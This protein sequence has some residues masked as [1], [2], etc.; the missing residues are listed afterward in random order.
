MDGTVP[1]YDG[2][3]RSA[4]PYTLS[5]L[6]AADV[7]N[8]QTVLGLYDGERLTEDWRLATERTRTGDELGVL[9]GG[10]LDLDAVDGICLSST[11]PTLIREWE[12]LAAR[13][14][15]APILVVGPGVKT[16]IPIRYDDPREVG[17]DRIVNSVAAKERYGA[18][19]IVVDFGTST[20]FDVVS[21][22]GEYVGGV[23]APGIETSMEALFARAAR[24]V[25][26]DYVE[27]PSAIGKTTV[28]GLQSG[29]V[30][31]FAGQVDGIVAAIRG[32]LGVEATRRGHW[33]PV[34]ARRASFEHD[35]RRRSAPDPRWPPH[36]VGSER[37]IVPS[38]TLAVFALAALAILAVPGPAVIYI[39]TRSIHQGRGAG[40][41]SVLGIHCGTLVH[42]VA[43]TVGLSAIL[44]SSASAFTVVK[45]LGAIY[46]IV[47]GIRTLLGRADEADTDPQRP[48]RR[49]RRDFAE[50]VVVNV[51]NPKT[52]LFFLAFLPQFVDPD[53][54]HA[55]LQILVLGLT[56]MVLGLI[57]DSMWAL[58]A[59]SAGETLRKSRRWAQVQRYVSGSVFVGLGVVTALTGSPPEGVRRGVPRRLRGLEPQRHPRR[60]DDRR[61]VTRPLGVIEGAVGAAERRGRWHG[62][63]EQRAADGDRHRQDARRRGNGK[64]PD[65]RPDPLGELLQ[66]TSA[67]DARREHGDLLAA[68]ACDDVGRPQA[69]A[70]PAHD[71]DQ[72]LVAD[73]VAEAVVDRLE[74]VEVDDEQARGHSATDDAGVLCGHRL[75]E[76]ATVRRARELVSPRI[77]LLCGKLRGGARPAALSEQQGRREA[78][79]R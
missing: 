4:R 56:F 1:P 44:V 46:L 69:L 61:R 58:A 67:P 77:C 23:L 75:L 25:K 73:G 48:P 43:A 33:R 21:A 66:L 22:A 16:G 3:G 59:G 55:W 12:R 52:A 42:L 72:H 2:T 64:L 20:N 32:E 41:T 71:L 50:G 79:S 36:R 49:K 17:P 7:G 53:L 78:T 30:Y 63:V 24:L 35:L 65:Q 74:P 68:P 70:E 6:L 26:V 9:L 14:A 54:G 15:Q 60:E 13:W 8:T 37:M 62:A 39:V 27:P 28:G 19:V 29:V 31:G 47:I 45:A 57:T 18:P 40:L 5:M 38:Q 10:L 34:G 51:L 11:V 76:R